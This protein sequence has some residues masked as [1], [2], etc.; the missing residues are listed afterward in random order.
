MRV[1][2]NN[3]MDLYNVMEVPNDFIFKLNGYHISLVLT[4]LHV[5]ARSA[6]TRMGCSCY[7]LHADWQEGDLDPQTTP[8][9]G[10][11]QI[12]SQRIL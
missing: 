10:A 12:A 3:V 11:H 4:H 7:D 8:K 9:E 2:H 1:P 5:K 6:T